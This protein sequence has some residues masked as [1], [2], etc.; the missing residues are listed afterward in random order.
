[1]PDTNLLLLAASVAVFVVVLRRHR[2]IARERRALLERL[3][4]LARHY[5]LIRR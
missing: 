3:D 1:M 4:Q 5:D 2:Q